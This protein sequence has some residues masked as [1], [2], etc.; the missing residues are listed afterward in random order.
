[1]KW[2][3]NMLL[4]LIL[5]SGWNANGQDSL[6]AYWNFDIL[7]DDMIYDVSVN[8]N[9][10]TNYGGELVPGVKGNAI[11]FDGV[12]A[13]IRIPGDGK[14]PPAMYSELGEGA[15]SFWFKADNIPT[16]YGIAPLFYYGAEEKC[17]FFDAA[18]K[19]FIIELGHS[20]IFRGSKELFFTAWKNGCT[21]PS[22]CFDSHHPITINEW[23]HI[24]VVVG[25]DYNT[26]YLNGIEM[27]NR[28]YNFGNASY[29]E[30]FEDAIAHE[31]LWLGKGHWDRTIQYFDGTIDELRIFNKA[32]SSREVIQ[33]YKD[34]DVFTSDRRIEIENKVN[35]YPNPVMGI[36]NYQTTETDEPLTDIKITDLKGKVVLHISNPAA[37][38]ALDT[39]NL[40]PGTYYVGF[41]GRDFSQSEKIIVHNN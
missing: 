38:G 22:F 9:H 15:I 24:V 29:S 33:L 26:G 40:I 34:T 19:G 10:G 2:I 35:I 14:P 18:N 4:V 11:S 23:H 7:D 20:P 28:D 5:Q 39:G 37:E 13:Y 21:Y 17:D 3:N 36:L 41:Y 25:K 16:T 12:S 6:V 30:F 27:V 1:M 31:K 8:A 32:L